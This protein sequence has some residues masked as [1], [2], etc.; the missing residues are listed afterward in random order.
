VHQDPSQVDHRDNVTSAVHADWIDGPRTAA[1]ARLWRQIIADLS[2]DS[3]RPLQH[4][5]GEP[6][7]P[8][9]LG[10]PATNDASV[11]RDGGAA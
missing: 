8:S 6:T 9:A 10:S 7:S 4:A 2:R 11:S 1:W 3:A 5:A